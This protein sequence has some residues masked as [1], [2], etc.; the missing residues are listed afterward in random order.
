MLYYDV[1]IKYELNNVEG[2]KDLTSEIRS[3]NRTSLRE[4]SDERK[5]MIYDCKDGVM[6]AVLMIDCSAISLTQAKKTF[7]T[8]YGKKYK[9]LFKSFHFVTASPKEL[10]VEE[11]CNSI[12]I[13]WCND[14][15]DRYT[16][17]SRICDAEYIF[18]G[19][20]DCDEF[21]LENKSATFSEVVDEAHKYMVDKSFFEELERIYSPLNKHKFYGIPVHY[22]INAASRETAKHLVE[23]LAKALYSNQRLKSSRVTYV[24]DTYPNGRRS[25]FDYLCDNSYA[26]LVAVECSDDD[27]ENSN[28][29]RDSQI[30]CQNIEECIKNYSSR[31]QFVLV[32]IGSRNKICKNCIAKLTA[33]DIDFIEI[34]EGRGSEKQ[35]KNY[36]ATLLKE[37]HVPY[38]KEDFVLPKQEDYSVID[39]A[40][41]FNK[42]KTG[43]IKNSIYKAYKDC[44]KIEIEK[45]ESLSNSYDKLQNMVGLTEIKSIIDQIISAQKLGKLRRDMG[46]EVADTAKHMIFTGNPGSAKTTV[47]RLLASILY[48]EHVL[49]K[50]KFVE[51][52]RQ[53]L[54]GKYV[55]WTAKQVE[56]KF[57]EA[58]GGILF[59][60]EAYSLVEKGGYY[61][62][63]AIN[64]IVQMMENYRDDVIVI[65]AGYPE[66]M[67]KFLEKNEGLRS[68]IAFHIDFPDYN[69][70]ELCDI[71]KLM[72]ADK[73]YTLDDEAAEKCRGIFEVAC[74]NAEFGNGRFVRNVLEQAI[75][76]QSAR[77]C[78][79]FS[80]EQVDEKVISILSAADFDINAAETYKSPKVA[81]GF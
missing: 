3:I 79:E 22:K 73:G 69:S 23:L 1:K 40:Q 51:C 65:F 72:T 50:S 47:A 4:D 39:I 68:R 81:I 2:E 29:A 6:N 25:D 77:I 80:N 12:E 62:D 55:G 49:S 11:A 17:G 52:G 44:K 48:D 60:D 19:C 37:N 66:K 32:D 20:V 30:K 34:G 43:S 70:D 41:A 18:N 54:V 8:E 33:S 46:L 71:L 36:L 45:P 14:Y 59:I 74:Q 13:G 42:I 5:L 15:F 57:I 21:V 10:T 67:K 61:G 56:A 16:E 64:T 26:A 24:T 7:E 63:E 53:D 35:A 38:A 76:K 78:S 58:K 28:Y 31:V 75:I 9:K 27:A